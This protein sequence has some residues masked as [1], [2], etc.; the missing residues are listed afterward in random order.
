MCK[1]QIYSL[2]IR[3]KCK[4][5][6]E[7]LNILKKLYYIFITFFQIFISELEA[8]KSLVTAYGQSSLQTS[9]GK[10]MKK[11]KKNGGK[12]HKNGKKGLKKVCR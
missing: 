4:D 7:T 9:W 1:I 8:K 3:A 12:L 11:G 2:S 6:K 10:E 5:S